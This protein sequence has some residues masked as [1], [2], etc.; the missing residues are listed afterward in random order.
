V[1]GFRL[2]VFATVFAVVG[3]FGAVTPAG[4]AVQGAGTGLISTSMLAVDLGDGLLGIRVLGDDTRS[5]LDKLQGVPEGATT[6]RPLEVTSAVAALSALNQALPTV[7]VRS[8]GPVDRKDN[9]GVDLGSL[10]LTQVVDGQLVGGAL[11]A[12]VDAAGAKSSML[13]DLTNLSLVGGLVDVNSISTV[14]GASALNDFTESGRLVDVDAISALNLGALLDGLGI[15]LPNLSL[16]SLA[17]LLDQLGELDAGGEVE[18]LL[19]A[20]GLASAGDAAGLTAVVNSLTTGI[21][22]AT[23]DLATLADT[24]LVPVCDD[25]VP[26][27]D[28]IAALVGVVSGT[29]C[30]DAV[31]AVTQR[32]TDGRTDLGGLLGIGTVDDPDVGGIQDLPGLLEILDDIELLSLEGVTA[33]LDAKATDD[34]NTSVAK[35]KAAIGDLTV[36]GLTVPGVDLL[37]G[38]QQLANVAGQVVGNVDDVLAMVDPDLA[39]L[40]AVDLLDTSG[41]GVS[42]QNGYVRSVA[43][44]IGATV[45]INPP[46]DL[47]TILSDLDGLTSVT[48]LLSGAGVPG[49]LPVLPN[50]A[51]MNALET[52]L[53]AGGPVVQAL[54]GGATVRVAGVSATSTFLPA[55]ATPAA[56]TPTSSLPRTGGDSGMLAMAAVLLIALAAGIRRTVL[57]PARID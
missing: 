17:G 14:L 13:T 34:I 20:L 8:Q 22:D 30:V 54:A 39:G 16:A 57:A 45:S 32:Q 25:I 53:A 33:G 35:V 24:S 46:S 21:A 37:A 44:L 10:G 28:P 48:E 55:G 11:A 2:A 52:V 7:G 18:N 9:I 23:A 15:A 36:G 42:K 31:T 41:T 1:R 49:V 40:I 6:L 27:P 43:N 12:L 4:A 51:G 47:A 50:V 3:A 29:T 26:L 56:P 19:D 38:A 5:N